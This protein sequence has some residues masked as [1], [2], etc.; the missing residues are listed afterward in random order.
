MLRRARA[1]LNWPNVE[2][3][4]GDL[5][6]AL[7][8]GPFGLVV[9]GLDALGLLTTPGAQLDLLRRVGRELAPGGRVVIDLLHQAELVDG[10]EGVPMLQH[11]GPC[12]ELG[13][14]VTKWVVR[15]VS[16]AAQQVRL[17]CF[18]DLTQPDGS[19]TRAAES[20]VLRF[21][22]PGEVRLLL[23]AAGLVLEAAYGG[24]DLATLEDSSDRMIFVAG[25]R[26][27]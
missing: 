24:Y 13:L 9:F 4:Q 25:P 16:W 17:E 1:R 8:H 26:T 10:A 11:S 2:L 21:F 15:H 12:E 7:P 19:L 5:G 14:D 20:V 18:Y 23:D 3:V 6:H 22:S 27:A